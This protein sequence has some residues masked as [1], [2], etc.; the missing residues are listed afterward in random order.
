[1]YKIF[2]KNYN[3]NNK[4]LIIAHNGHIQKEGYNNSKKIEWFGNYL[5]KKFKNEYLSIGNTFYNGSYLAKNIDKNYKLNK[6]NVNRIKKLKTNIYFINKKNYKNIIYEGGSFGS[7]K[8][9]YLYFTKK[10]LNKR[11]DILIVINYEK[12]YLSIY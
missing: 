9:P 12:P 10:K 5:Y 6:I 7:T 1:M 8:K 11:F 2:M 4:Y 3:K